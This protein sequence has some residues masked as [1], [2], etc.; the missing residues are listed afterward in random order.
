[1]TPLPPGS[2]IG[3]VGGGQLGRMTAIAAA[4]FG[5]RAVVLAPDADCP[6]AAVARHIHAPYEDRG[7][8]EAFARAVD[9]VTFEFENVSSA[10]L[11]LLA[12]LVPVRPSPSVLRTSQCRVT[13]KSFLNAHG[14]PTAPWRE[15]GE[16]A[17]LD[18]AIAEIGLPAILKTTRLG[19]DGRGQAVLRTPAD[20]DEAWAGLA[21]KPLILEGMIDFAAE[22][23]VIV[24]R[25]AGGIS[26][27]DA[28]ENRHRGGILRL[29]LAPARIP[30][31]L[32]VEADA[33]ARRA[34]E[35]LALEGLL[36]VE[37]FVDGNGRLLANEIAPRPHNSGHWSIEACRESQFAMH[38]RAVCGL[39]LPSPGRFADAAMRNLIGPDDMAD[40]NRLVATEGAI[41][42]HYGKTEA[43]P[44]RK[45]G[46]VTHLFPRGALPGDLA[47]A[48]IAGADASV[49]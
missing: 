37:M 8:L 42:H 28:V 20:L 19:Y 27:F 25:G 29:S 10:A 14:I 11:E 18:A 34:A 26:T 41:V 44:G 21:P 32:A 9:V 36:A 4:R 31:A 5:Y 33:L 35:A 17:G 12:S 46:H 40:W 15:V 13:E 49:A 43:R 6:A 23:S 30:P 3:I 48:A 22:I 16:R 45:M 2:T 1:M 24:A 47:L 39:P 38:V 7:A